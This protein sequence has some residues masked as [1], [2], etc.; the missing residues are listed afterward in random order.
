MKL[1]YPRIQ[2]VEF[3]IEVVG[4]S[5]YQKNIRDAVFY[6]IMIEKEDM[7]YK[8]TKLDAALV[9]EDDN[10]FDPGNAVRIDIGGN[11]IGYLDRQDA[12]NYRYSLAKIGAPQQ[13]YYCNASAF[14]KRKTSREK[15]NFG[16]WLNINP[17]QLVVLQSSPP[18]K[19][20]FG[21]F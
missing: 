8:D 9:L 15:M 12:E 7:E 18:R 13:T 19:K 20:L 10:K 11:I 6:D 21:I 14:G 2:P 1:K 17:R 16:I 5:N 4:E 3:S